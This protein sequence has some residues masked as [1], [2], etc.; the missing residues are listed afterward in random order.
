MDGGIAIGNSITGFKGKRGTQGST[1]I[2]LQRASDTLVE[3][4]Y[5][6]SS[7]PVERFWGIWISDSHNVTVLSNR[8]HR[9][10][11]GI[12]YA[13]I[14]ANTS[15]KYGNN[16]TERVEFPYVGVGTDIGYNF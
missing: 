3:D 10:A 14:A 6:Q 4:N 16:I 15:G 11:Y 2:R 13:N 1:G 12:E 5:I 7:S 9:I 8:L